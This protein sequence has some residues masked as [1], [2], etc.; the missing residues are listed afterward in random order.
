MSGVYERIAGIDEAGRGALAGPVVA[1]AV[2]FPQGYSFDVP[3]DGRW[4]PP[5]QQKRSIVIADSK[6]LSP[7]A[8]E[9][10]FEWLTKNCLFGVGIS[11]ASVIEEIG[12]LKANE[13]AMQLA[14]GVLMLQTDIAKVFVD[15]KDA[16]NFAVPHQSIIRG[17]SIEPSIAAAS[18][19]AKVTRDRMMTKLDELYPLYGFTGHKGYASEMHRANIQRYGPCKEHRY[20]FLSRIVAQTSLAASPTEIL[21]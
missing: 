5:G 2:V 12:I 15:G 18:I 1:A 21:L 4:I 11:D 8:R 16:Y 6:Q 9:R 17:D 14:L 3:T 13:R 10:A 20:S 19:I 7:A